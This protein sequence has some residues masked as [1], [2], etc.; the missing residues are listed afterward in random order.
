MNGE[1]PSNL[2]LSTQNVESPFNAKMVIGG[3]YSNEDN[4]ILVRSLLAI[5][6]ERYADMHPIGVGGR[7]IHSAKPILPIA[8]VALMPNR[9]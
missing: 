9:K 7:N 1:C 4:V 3:V 5:G 8:N 2:M 6:S